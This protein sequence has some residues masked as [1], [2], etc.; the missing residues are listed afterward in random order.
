[1][2][3]YCQQNTNCIEEDNVIQLMEKIE[4]LLGSNCESNDESTQKLT[5]IALK[6]IG[7]AGIFTGSDYTLKKCLKVINIKIL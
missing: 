7:N 6:A 2:H 5:I 1:M 4:L 3:S